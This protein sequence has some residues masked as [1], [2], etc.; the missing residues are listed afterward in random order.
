[1]ATIVKG[2]L[3][4]TNFLIELLAPNSLNRSHAEAYLQKFQ[5]QQGTELFCSTIS[6]AEYCVKGRIED[7]P[8]GTIL[9]LPFNLNHAEQ[10]GAY[11]AELSGRRGK[12]GSFSASKVAIWHDVKLLAQAHCE[13]RISHLITADKKL[14]SHSKFLANKGMCSVAPIDLSIPPNQFFGTLL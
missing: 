11:A 2:V 5:D 4:D 10:A 3:L 9:A 1:M 6:I 13:Q 8:I 14:I 12:S 7:L